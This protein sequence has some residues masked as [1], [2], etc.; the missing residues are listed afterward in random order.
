[1]KASVGTYILENWVNGDFVSN[2]LG[3]V[4]RENK[5]YLISDV[6]RTVRSYDEE[7][8]KMVHIYKWA[9]K[10]FKDSSEFGFRMSVTHLIN[11]DGAMTY[12]VFNSPSECKCKYS[13][14]EV[15]GNDLRDIQD[16]ENEPLS[17]LYV[18]KEMGY[19]GNVPDDKF[20][21]LMLT[22]QACEVGRLDYDIIMHLKDL[23]KVSKVFHVS[24]GASSIMENCNQS[25]LTK[26][27]TLFHVN[28]FG[29]DKKDITREEDRPNIILVI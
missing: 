2:H 7:P 29:G 6:Q 19:G 10:F 20:F 11:T 8:R 1:M 18:M 25:I 21:K 5:K 26:T 27:A 4:N 16:K 12:E 23:F 13:F 22:E 24:G 15:F 9:T 3:Y 17:T 28:T 14:E